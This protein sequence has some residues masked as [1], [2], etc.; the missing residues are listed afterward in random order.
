MLETVQRLGINVVLRRDV[1]EAG[2][3]AEFRNIAFCYADLR[4]QFAELLCILVG[5][6]TSWIANPFALARLISVDDRVGDHGRLVAILR[7]RRHVEQLD[8]LA[9]LDRQAGAKT[10]LGPI[11]GRRN[12]A[13]YRRREFRIMRQTELVY[14]REQHFAALNQLHLSE[15]VTREQ[16]SGHLPRRIAGLVVHHHGRLCGVALWHHLHVYESH[17]NDCQSN[18]NRQPPVRQQYC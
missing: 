14:Y 10:L 7:R 17:D 2:A 5:A 4:L 15:H 8:S 1:G 11:G 12:A 16:L 18:E 3:L 13:G 9:L 6:A